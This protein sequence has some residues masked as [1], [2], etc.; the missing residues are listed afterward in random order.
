M[1]REPPLLSVLVLTED[2]A[3]SANDVIVTLVKKMLWLLDPHYRS[4]LVAF[5]PADEVSRRV[6]RGNLWKSRSPRDQA[7]IVLLGRAIADRLLQSEVPGFVLFHIDGDV[8]WPRRVDS[9][10]VQRFEGFIQDYVR[11]SLDRALRAQRQERREPPSDEEIAHATEVALRRLLL[12]V[13]F[14]SIEAWLYQNT[15]E[16]ARRCAVSCEVHLDLIKKWE[17]IPGE[18]DDLEKPKDQL[19]LGASHNLA[20]AEQG[21]P[22]QRAFDVGKSF[23]AAVLRL[24]ECEDLT[25]ALAR[26]R[27]PTPPA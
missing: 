18:L 16:T 7:R 27:T 17:A 4:H 21:F 3:K 10:N 8:S 5:R 20:L 25:A 24:L 9:D 22:A 1:S 12:M 11:P 26:T 19:C 14:Y 23:S 6:M 15:A 2:S 13:P